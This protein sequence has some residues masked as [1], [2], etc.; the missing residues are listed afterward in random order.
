MTDL[1]LA[2]DQLNDLW[3]AA[4]PLD[5]A[6]FG[7]SVA[8]DRFA[9]TALR[10]HPENDSEVLGVDDPRY[11]ELSKGWLP[12]S[13]E[14]R[15]A[16][17]A[18]VTESERSYLLDEIYGGRLW[19]IGF[20]TLPTGFDEPARVPRRLFL[21]TQGRQLRMPTDIDWNR[22]EVRDGDVCY[23]HVRV[24]KPAV[25][26]NARPAEAQPLPEA[27]LVQEP[28]S[29]PGK[30]AT[31]SDQTVQAMAPVTPRGKGGRPRTDEEIRSKVRE[32]WNDPTFQAMKNRTEQAGEVRARLKSPQ[33]RDVDEMQGYGLGKIKRIIGE[34]A[35]E[36]RRS[37]K[38]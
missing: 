23:F 21:A 31:Q 15:Q 26:A 17:L 12:N 33:A 27:A 37:A 7:F 30:D 11:Q 35:T 38:N 9:L 24:C 13:W 10:T 19:A 20:R 34:V 28:K 32:L 29:E 1:E 14:A 2:Q 16:K 25:V 18:Y 36:Q 8:L 4:T 5:Q 6:W 22:E 3:E